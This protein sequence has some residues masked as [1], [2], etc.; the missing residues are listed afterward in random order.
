[1]KIKTAAILLSTAVAATALPVVSASGGY[2]ADAEVLEARPIIETVYEP[3][4]VCRYE[5]RSKRQA[6]G[7]SDKTT[8]K[9]IGGV[10]GGAAGS[11]LGKG[12]GRDAA[13]AIGAILGGEVAAQDG[14]L[15]EGEIIG[16][17]AGGLLGNQL[18]GGSGKTATTAAGA[19][20]GSIVGDT[21]QNGEQVA[22][23]GVVKE[24]VRVCD[25]EERSKKIVTGYEVDLEYDGRVFQETVDKRPG[26]TVE[27]YVD[28]SI[29]EE[30]YTSQR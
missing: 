12:S 11:A 30:A 5:Y 18:G 10:V 19:V 16:G 25:I 8:D 1:M 2:F 14:E 9:V 4:E 24:K 26:D 27:I 17:I 13:A 6:S 29:V 28:I 15:S 23:P 20:I 22:K 7:I 21:I 3:V